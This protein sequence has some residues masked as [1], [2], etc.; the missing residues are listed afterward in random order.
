M[1]SS[2]T[3][4]DSPYMEILNFP[5]LLNMDYLYVNNARSLTT[6]SMPELAPEL[7]PDLDS[8]FISTAAFIITDAV[9]LQNLDFG[10][11]TGFNH[12]ALTG[13]GDTNFTTIPIPGVTAIQTL[14]ISSMV[15]DFPNLT[16]VEHVMINSISYGGLRDQSLSRVT[17]VGDLT[18][19]DGLGLAYGDSAPIHPDTI[20]GSLVLQSLNYAEGFGN[21]L[22][23]T[24]TSTIGG[25]AKIE[26]NTNV[27]IGFDDLVTIGGNFSFANNTNCPLD[28]QQLSS[29]EDLIVVDNINMTLPYL[30]NLK[31]AKNI[32]LRGYID[33]APGANIF[34]A[35]SLV[36][37][38][39][40]IENWN[41]DFSCSKL[42]SQFRESIIHNLSCNGTDNST[43]TTPSTLPSSGSNAA[44]RLSDGA[45]AGIGVG[46]G[47]IILGSIIAVVWLFLHYRRQQG[48][49]ADDK[50]LS[51]QQKEAQPPTLSGLYETEDSR[52]IREAPDGAVYEMAVPPA[53]K[54]DDHVREMEA[55][56]A[57]KPDDHVREMDCVP[58]EMPA[59]SPG[60]RLEGTKSTKKP[61]NE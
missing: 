5:K 12:L 24:G 35:L 17:S 32:H 8:D 58:G 9:S 43:A 42:V 60:V 20:N 40:I 38:S 33:P 21:S 51:S 27:R 52:I 11:A 15:F 53:E 34:P 61:S 39:M 2:L 18:V 31:T 41:S 30:P 4:L 13:S 36:S 16:S 22:S 45:W 6:I 19:E 3:V 54:P 37:G 23:F 55:P 44:D 25:N 28:I 46:V 26:S 10:N 56:P 48:G 47:T 29:V 59:S 50:S 14:E 7:T 1:I 49:T 57:E